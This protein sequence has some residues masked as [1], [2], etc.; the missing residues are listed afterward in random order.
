MSLRDSLSFVSLHLQDRT[1]ANSTAAVV[2]YRKWVQRLVSAPTSGV[3]CCLLF[4]VVLTIFL[5]CWLGLCR[6]LSVLLFS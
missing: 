2:I 6:F 5:H 4:P 1:S 3:C